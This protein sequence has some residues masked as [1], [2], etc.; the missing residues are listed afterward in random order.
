MSQCGVSTGFACKQ[1]V[2]AVSHGR[3]KFNTFIHHS[4]PVFSRKKGGDFPGM[5]YAAFAKL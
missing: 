1:A 4:I 3:L 5:H 2:I